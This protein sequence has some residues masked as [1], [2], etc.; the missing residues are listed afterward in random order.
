MM[1]SMATSGSVELSD[2]WHRDYSRDRTVN[3]LADLMLA[4]AGKDAPSQD[5]KAALRG[6]VEELY[7]AF[8]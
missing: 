5:V 8:D 3:F 4:D 7:D 1:S 2:E 6:R